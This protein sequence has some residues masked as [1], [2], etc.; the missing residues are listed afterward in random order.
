VAISFNKFNIFVQDV[1]RKVHNLH[2]DTVK[3]MF[4][5]S[6]P[7]ATNT[8]T[9]DLTDIS[10]GN[11]YSAGGAAVTGQSFTQTSGTA[12]FLATGP[13]FTATGDI[14]PFRYIVVYNSTA[15]N[16]LIGWWDRG[17]SLTLKNGETYTPTIDGT[18]GILTLA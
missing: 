16:A 3:V 11:G 4:T 12:K 2:T 6:A 8:T 1:G 7:V 9:A 13:T 15:S 5:N 14:G 17:A 10:A 18:N